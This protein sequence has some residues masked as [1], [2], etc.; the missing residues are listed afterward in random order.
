MH[1]NCSFSNCSLG[2]YLLYGG[3]K[4]HIGYTREQKVFALEEFT[5]QWG[6][7]QVN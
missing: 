4:Q 2:I 3:F 7:K 5:G 1:P 6:D